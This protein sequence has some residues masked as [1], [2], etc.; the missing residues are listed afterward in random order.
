MLCSQYVRVR[1]AVFGRDE[2]RADGAYEGLEGVDEGD[3]I[4]QHVLRQV[5]PK[6]GVKV[7]ARGR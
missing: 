1:I 3:P 5:V 2:V 7:K 6:G 4:H